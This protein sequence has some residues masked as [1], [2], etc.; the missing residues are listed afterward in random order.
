MTEIPMASTGRSG[1]LNAGIL[2]RDAIRERL[3]ATSLTF[4][5]LILIALVLLVPVLWLFWLSAFDAAGEL[6]WANYERMGRSIYIRTLT[7]TFRIAFIVTLCCALMGYP[8]AYLMSQSGRR[9]SLV[10]L[11]CVLLPFWTSVLVRTYAW[12]VL[13][14]RTG[15]INTWLQNWGIIDEPLALVHN[16]LGT[17]IGMIHV[18]LPFMILPLY[19]SMK[20]VDSSLMLAASNCGAT[21]T[22]AFWQVYFP[23]TITGVSS[24]AGLIFVLCLGFFVTPVLLGGGRTYMWAMQIADNISLYGN[25]GAASA[26][27]VVLVIATAIVLLAVQ[28]VLRRAGGTK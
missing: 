3:G 10:I 9:V 8:V 25:W 12:L 7:T 5:G 4:P 17:I 22:Q 2:R 23:Q 15:L 24:G 13:L 21:P 19:A 20:A 18:M 1:V 26:L 14:Q 16:E 28:F 11:L 6:S 27:G